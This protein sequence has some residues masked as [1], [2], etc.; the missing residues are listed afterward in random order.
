MLGSLPEAL[1]ACHSC[2]EVEEGARKPT[3]LPTAKKR[4]EDAEPAY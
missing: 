3:E 1:G 4:E 2:V